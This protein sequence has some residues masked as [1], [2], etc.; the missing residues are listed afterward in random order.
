MGPLSIQNTWNSGWAV[1]KAYWYLRNVTSRGAFIRIWGRP[2][3]RNHGV[4]V[5]GEKARLVST[6]A[7]LELV[8]DGGRLE[9]GA[10]TFINYGC[11]IAATELVQI[12]EQCSIGTYAI[13]MD[14]NY[15][16]LEPERRYER[17][18]SAPVVL[19][20]NVWL[21][22]R[23]IVLPGVTIG[24]GSVIGAGSVVTRSIPARC[25]AAGVPAKV[26]RQL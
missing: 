3:I 16:R 17:P 14:N 19:E 23:V 22:A 9:I 25:L 11:S 12:G 5:I 7:T 26:L 1:M 21:G 4:M 24:E 10:R 18:E 20:G 2:S 8:A 13:I 6:I 15:H